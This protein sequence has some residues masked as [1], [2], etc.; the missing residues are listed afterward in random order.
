[1]AGGF[2]DRDHVIGTSVRI[3]SKLLGGSVVKC[4]PRDLE[5]LGSNPGW[6]IP[7]TF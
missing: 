7:K 4:L 2:H 1:V 5:V 6:V 3:I